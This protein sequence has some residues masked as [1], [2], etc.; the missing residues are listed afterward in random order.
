MRDWREAM[1]K[2]AVQA[3]MD[4]LAASKRRLALRW[5]DEARPT[6]VPFQWGEYDRLEGTPVAG[7]YWRASYDGQT[8]PVHIREKAAD[9]PGYKSWRF[10]DDAKAWS[11]RPQRGPLYETERDAKLAALWSACDEAAAK[12]ER[13]WQQFTDDRGFL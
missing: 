3:A 1:P 4:E 2:W 12:L 5:P 6:P 13:V 10:S 11:T 9:E 7:T 8:R